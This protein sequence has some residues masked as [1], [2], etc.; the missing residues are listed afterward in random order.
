MERKKEH[1]NLE[2][3]EECVNGRKLVRKGV[4]DVRPAKEDTNVGNK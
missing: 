3:R 2:T 4:K 1:G